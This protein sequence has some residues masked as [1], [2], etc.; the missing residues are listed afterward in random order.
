[1]DNLYREQLATNKSVYCTILFIS[2][3]FTMLLPFGTAGFCKHIV[4]SLLSFMQFKRQV[5]SSHKV[6]FRALQTC[7]FDCCRQL[8]L[9]FTIRCNC[10]WHT[11]STQVRGTCLLFLPPSIMCDSWS[12][13]ILPSEHAYGSGCRTGQPKHHIQWGFQ[14]VQYNILLT[15]CFIKSHFNIIFPSMPMSSMWSPSFRF[16]HQN[17]AHTLPPT[18]ANV[19]PSTFITLDQ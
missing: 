6:K 2:G 17:S 13:D 19:H 4:H 7:V 12:A 8:S 3:S 5:Q 10:I 1:M 11:G 14:A 18:H 9:H 16:P 15:S